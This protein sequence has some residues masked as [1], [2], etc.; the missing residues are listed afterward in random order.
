MIFLAKYCF[1]IFQGCQ[2]CQGKKKKKK[3]V[4]RAITNLLGLSD[5]DTD[6]LQ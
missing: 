5:S 4:L 6:I 1:G 3:L 2:G